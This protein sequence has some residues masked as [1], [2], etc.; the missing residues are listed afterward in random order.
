[1]VSTLPA[2]GC[3]TAITTVITIYCCHQHVKAS[4]D[5]TLTPFTFTCYALEPSLGLENGSGTGHPSL[6]G[7]S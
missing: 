2:N 6:A 1:M 4:E 3:S 5:N 7:L